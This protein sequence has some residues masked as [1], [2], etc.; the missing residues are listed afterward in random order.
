MGVDSP[1]ALTLQVLINNLPKDGVLYYDLVDPRIPD[2]PRDTSAQAIAAA[3]L[4]MLS[5]LMVGEER[6]LH[7]AQ[8]ARLLASLC[9]GYLVQLEPGDNVSRGFLRGGCYFWSR[10]RGV[11]S[12]LMFG[13]YYVLEAMMRY[14]S[15]MMWQ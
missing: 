6:K 8:G 9:S 2:V 5:E 13:D 3:G 10:D 7:F 1:L 4:L 14:L 15:A 11:D 12:E